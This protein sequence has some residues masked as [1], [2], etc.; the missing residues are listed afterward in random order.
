MF[1][2]AQNISYSAAT[3]PAALKE[4]A[5]VIKR[6]EDITFTVKDIDAA[7]Y[8]VHQVYTVLDEEG[9]SA[10]L[11][12]ELTFK[13]RT[14]DD[15]DIKV[16][17]AS[18]KQIN[19]YKKKDL[20]RF[21]PQDGLITDGMIHFLQINPI[22]YPVTVE[23]IYEIDYTGTL[24]YP[25]YHIQGSDE[26]VEYS[27][28]TARVPID[29]DLRFTEQKVSLK[30]SILNEV[31]YKAYKWEV[32]NMPAFKDEDGTVG[33]AFY[34]PSIILAPNKFRHFN[35]YGEMTSW[36]SFGQWGYDLLKGLDEL[37][38]DRKAYFA[39]MVK[40]AKSDREKVAL[41][42]DHMQKNF[43]Y[44]SIQLG[45]G[46][47]KPFPAQ[48]TDEKK[49]GDC[50]GLSLYMVAA[51]KA[52]GIKSYCA[53]INSKYNQEAVSEAFPCDRFDHVILCVPQAKDSIWL[54]CTS[55]T[56]EFGVLGTFTENRNALLLTENGGVLVP[57]PKSK[58]SNN[59]ML[60]STVVSLNEDGSGSTSTKVASKGEYKEMLNSMLTAKKDDQKKMI[61]WGLG[62]KQPD[63]FSVVKKEE[64]LDID[65]KIEK[66]P[67][68]SAG[69]KMFLNPRINSIWKTVL[70]KSDNRKQDFYFDSPFIKTDSTVYNLPDNYVAESVPLP[71]D[72]K[73]EFGTYKTSYTY[74]KEKNQIVSVARLELTQ[75][76]IPSDKYADVKKFFD[77]VMSEDTQKMVI[78]K[79]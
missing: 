43:R 71:A 53:F 58:S 47:V 67:Q 11:F 26:A 61:V 25:A 27:A 35:T 10:L 62:F 6:Y 46:G 37:P 1:S 3:I 42:Y 66:I 23:Y 75:I 51:L 12:R 76:K 55:N 36:K 68:F 7:S 28:Y 19:K 15:V 48:F 56:S 40:D 22:S 69:S 44:V 21:A 8:A 52:V 39:S 72:I 59:L 9:R 70:P 18:G 41:I 16:Y 24:Q 79:N 45:I 57:T 13:L 17:D 64:T 54:E 73:C 30:P 34:Y 5:H 38:A 60:T 29:L 49:Y 77:G 65:L 31:K 78:K 50:K 63:E 33:A 32:K 74:V 2:H 4:G 20:N 14:I